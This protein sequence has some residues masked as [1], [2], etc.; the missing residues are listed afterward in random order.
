MLTDWVSGNTYFGDGEREVIYVCSVSLQHC[1]LLIDDAL[2][3]LH[4]FVIDPLAG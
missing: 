2:S 4:G 1:R 3:K